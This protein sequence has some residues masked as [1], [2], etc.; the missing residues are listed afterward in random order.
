MFLSVYIYIYI[1][2]Y[3]IS[4]FEAAARRG[5][6][7][8]VFLN[9]VK[10]VVTPSRNH[11]TKIVSIV[12]RIL[13]QQRKVRGSSTPFFRGLRLIFSVS[14]SEVRIFSDWRSHNCTLSSER[15]LKTADDDLELCIQF[16]CLC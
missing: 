11:K 4:K 2:I 12:R 5:G 10:N 16:Y 15:P 3:I 14:P 1:Y 7:D 13:S 9:S 8:V 6:L